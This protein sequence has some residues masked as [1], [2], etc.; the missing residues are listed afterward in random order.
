MLRSI[1][2]SK[3]NREA[4]FL[5]VLSYIQIHPA[6]LNGSSLGLARLEFARIKYLCTLPRKAFLGTRLSIAYLSNSCARI[7]KK[8]CSTNEQ[9]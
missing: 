6:F 3:D 5:A 1:Q 7:L 9:M 2:I 8:C 4:D